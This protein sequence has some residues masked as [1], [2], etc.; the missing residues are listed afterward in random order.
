MRGIGGTKLDGLATERA[1]GPVPAEAPPHPNAVAAIDHAVAIK[2]DLERTA[3]ALEAA[4]LEPRRIR[5]EPTPAGAPRQAF[6]R[7]GATILEV[8]QE[9]AEAVTRGRDRDRPAFFWGPAFSVADLDAHRSSAAFSA[10]SAVNAALGCGAACS[11]TSIQE[12]IGHRSP[13]HPFPSGGALP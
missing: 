4:G 1:D 3:A 8:V 13:S 6:F 12:V 11:Y 9:P 10:C 7:L 2:P 5:E